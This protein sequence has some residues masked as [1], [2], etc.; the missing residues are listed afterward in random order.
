[1]PK[2]E[3]DPNGVPANSKGSKLDAG[4]PAV[5]RGL[6]D[7]FPRACTAVAD[8]STRGAQKYTWKGWEN[9]PDGENRYLDAMARHIVKEAVEGLYDV[10]E[11]GLGAEVLHRSQVAWNAL[12]ALELTL[13]RLEKKEV[14]SYTQ[15][16][17][18]FR[19][20][21]EFKS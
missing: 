17:S 19:A 20:N 6:L 14:P 4:K 5:F 13:R 16:S 18:A 21:Y 2:F 9:V 15:D 11:G 1:M 10:G 12:A 3:V 8:V 7:Y